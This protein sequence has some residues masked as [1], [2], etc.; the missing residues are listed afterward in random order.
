MMINGKKMTIPWHIKNLNISHVDKK[1]VPKI[2]DWLKGIYW[3]HMK[4]S[5]VKKLDYLSMEIYL[6]LDW[7]SG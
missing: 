3:S 5:Q 4:E 2:I 1:V 7:R 6:L